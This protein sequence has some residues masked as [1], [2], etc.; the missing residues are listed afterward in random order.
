MNTHDELLQKFRQQAAAE[1]EGVSKVT[2]IFAD[3][4]N[5]SEARIKF[6]DDLFAEMRQDLISKLERAKRIRL[7]NTSGSHQL[8]LNLFMFPVSTGKQ[9]DILLVIMR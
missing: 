5:I 6:T 3:S 7:G 9:A 1:L 2:S 4:Y 8:L